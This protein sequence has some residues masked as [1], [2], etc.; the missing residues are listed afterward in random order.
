MLKKEPF[1]CCGLA[2]K[3]EE[4]ESPDTRVDSGGN[5]RV[6]EPVKMI[7]HQYYRYLECGMRFSQDE[8]DGKLVWDK[9]LHE[10]KRND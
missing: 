10:W 4:W 6:K 3:M 5:I 8:V 2:P 9:Q 1:L 7:K